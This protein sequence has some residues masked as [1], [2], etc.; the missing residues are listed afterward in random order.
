[1]FLC[2]RSQTISIS[3]SISFKP[4]G[5]C[6][7]V[8]KRAQVGI[9]NHTTPPLAARSVY[10]SPMKNVL[11]KRVPSSRYVNKWHQKFSSV[12]SIPCG[13]NGLA[14]SS[15]TRRHASLY[16]SS[17]TDASKQTSLV[18]YAC[19]EVR[20]LMVHSKKKNCF[21]QK[22]ENMPYVY[23]YIYSGVHTFFCE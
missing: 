6:D 16:K 4:P 18:V 13:R 10:T 14:M 20:A 1:M 7:H 19:R 8:R 22:V 3:I 2:E 23:I 11:T 9:S 12:W 17:N 15:P 21:R 5:R